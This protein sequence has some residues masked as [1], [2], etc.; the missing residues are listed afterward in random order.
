MFDRNLPASYLIEMFSVPTTKFNRNPLISLGDEA[1]GQTCRH[2][3]VNYPVCL[4]LVPWTK[5]YVD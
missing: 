4:R 1:R 3:C 2:T 5:V